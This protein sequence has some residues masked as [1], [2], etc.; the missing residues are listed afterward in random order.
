LCKECLA[1]IDK[2]LTALPALYAQ[3]EEELA[4]NAQGSGFVIRV[5]G[6]KRGGIFL[7]E[8]IVEARTAIEGGLSSWASLIADERVSRSL[9]A[10]EPRV[11]RLCQFLLAHLDW[12]AA[13]PAAPDFAQEI[14]DL[15]AMAHRS[16]QIDGDLSH[17]D[18]HECVMPGCRGKL[19]AGVGSGDEPQVRCELGHAWA[20]G[21]WLLLGRQLN[22][23]Q[24]NSRQGADQHRRLSTK[25]AAVA[26]GVEQST[27][28]QWVRRGKLS[29]YGS[30]LHAEYDLDELTAL[31]QARS[32]RNR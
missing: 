23:R 22:S 1:K 3:C 13:H 11:T 2:S 18:A 24:L 27:I 17:I 28:R 21:E 4:A 20:A 16:C 5:A 14:H 9:E 8:R 32:R 29:R 6:S 12:L 26:L 19:S 7:D 10:T 31:A 15:V 25:D 30:D